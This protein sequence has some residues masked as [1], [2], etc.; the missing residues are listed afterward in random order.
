MN[1][2]EQ[3]NNA[4]KTI[5]D[6][7]S[8]FFALLP[9][10]IIS[11]I[12]F[13]VL[14]IVAG[15]IS[16]FV[17]RVLTERSSKGV[18]TAIGRVVHIALLFVA[19]LFSVAIITPSVGAAQLLQ[20]LGVG[21]VAI[22]FAFRDILQNFLAGLLILLRQPFKVGD[23]IVFGDFEGTVSEISTRSTWLR[24]F[25]GHDIT[26]PNGQLFTNPVS[27]VSKD[28]LARSQY[29]VGISYDADIEKAKKIALG[30]LNDN[31]RIDQNKG[32]DVGVK[33]L[34]D[35]A[36]VLRMRWWSKTSDMYGLKQEILQ[37]V[38][39]AYDKNKIGI[40]YPHSQLVVPETLSVKSSV[41]K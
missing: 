14:W 12:V 5:Q 15:F 22:G 26:I 18:G 19:F 41:K 1:L 31:E 29:D 13:V 36:V 7:V 6:M 21:S 34:G 30:I 2:T 20:V 9:Q 10:I 11:I 17:T 8:G 27:V 28:P 38:K 39:E 3:T 25:D 4:F 24:T 40:P 16:R 37:S 32:P 33:D 35:S 23:W